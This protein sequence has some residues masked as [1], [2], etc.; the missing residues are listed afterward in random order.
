[1]FTDMQ[2]IPYIRTSILQAR[3]L[4]NKFHINE[5]TIAF[6]K[7][8]SDKHSNTVLVAIFQDFTMR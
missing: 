3:I 6:K 1:M 7:Q 8:N 5:F 4:K 2:P